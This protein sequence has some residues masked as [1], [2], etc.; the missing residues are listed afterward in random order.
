M[1]SVGEEAKWK[2]DL[3]QEKEKLVKEVENLKE[4]DTKMKNEIEELNKKVVEAEW[5]AE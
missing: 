3:E 5:K 4:S 2:E 1:K